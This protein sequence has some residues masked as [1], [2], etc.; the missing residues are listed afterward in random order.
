MPV[1]ETA[2]PPACQPGQGA[3]AGAGQKQDDALIRC[4]GI[5]EDTRRDVVVTS[6][7]T[8]QAA[9]AKALSAHHVAKNRL[10]QAVSAKFPVFPKKT[11]LL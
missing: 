6:G 3:P 11:G 1:T 7:T 4:A 5:W 8:D 2:A 10:S 9:R